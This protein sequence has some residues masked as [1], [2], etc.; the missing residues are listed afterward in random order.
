MSIDYSSPTILG[1]TEFIKDKA[2]K[3]AWISIGGISPTI[4]ANR[5]VEKFTGPE[6]L[7]TGSRYRLHTTRTL[8]FLINGP[9]T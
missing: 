5:L 4:S 7:L 2:I 3:K 8:A 1:T 6:Q 9:L